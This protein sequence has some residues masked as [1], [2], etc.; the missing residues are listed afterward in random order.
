MAA[1]RQTRR[2]TRA[3][4][5]RSL[6]RPE[7]SSSQQAPDFEAQELIQQ[8]QRAIEQQDI[9]NEKLKTLESDYLKERDALDL[10]M[11]DPSI[12][13]ERFNKLRQEISR[14]KAN[15]EGFKYG[16]EEAKKYAT[17]E[18]NTDSLVTFAFRSGDSARERSLSDLK[19]M[20]VSVT[21][22]KAQELPGIVTRDEFRDK[23]KLREPKKDLFG[24]PVR[25]RINKPTPTSVGEAPSK[26]QTFREDP[27]RFLGPFSER[28][29]E[30]VRFST[31]PS[32]QRRQSFFSNVQELERQAGEIGA[33]L[34]GKVGSFIPAGKTSELIQVRERRFPE[35]G[36]SM[37]V[38][39]DVNVKL[40]DSGLVT[41]QERRISTPEE[42]GRAVGGFL[43]RAA[44]ATTLFPAPEFVGLETGR[45]RFATPTPSTE[46]I[47]EEIRKQNNLSKAEFENYKRTGEGQE[48]L[49]EVKDYQALLERQRLQGLGMSILSGAGLA[50]G[51]LGTGSLLKSADDIVDVKVLGSKQTGSAVDQFTFLKQLEG[52][53]GK[54][55]IV[56]AQDRLQEGII[57][58]TTA[59]G[60]VIDYTYKVTEGSIGGGILGFEGGRGIKGFVLD[61]SGNIVSK[62]E[63]L[64]LEIGS[65]DV[66][67]I[68]T[69][70]IIDRPTGNLFGFG[71]KREQIKVVTAEEVRTPFKSEAFPLFPERTQVLAVKTP[72]QATIDI[73]KGPQ[74]IKFFED[75]GEAVTRKGVKL[76]EGTDVEDI[77]F[78]SSESFEPQVFAE[79]FGGKGDRTFATTFRTETRRPFNILDITDDTRRITSI[80]EEA[81]VSIINSGDDSLLFTKK[82]NIK[83]ATN[84]VLSKRID[85]VNKI[86]KLNDKKRELSNKLS[87]TSKDQSA[88]SKLD[89][90]INSLQNKLNRP[91]MSATIASVAKQTISVTKTS[92][93]KAAFGIFSGGAIAKIARSPQSVKQPS[94]SLTGLSQP[95]A[96]SESQVE[97]LSESQRQ[98]PRLQEG[99]NQRA[100]QG[101]VQLPREGQRN[102][103]IERTSLAQ[104]QSQSQRLRRGLDM[105][106]SRPAEANLPRSPG[107][108]IALPSTD[109]STVRKNLKKMK[110]DAKAYDVYLKRGRTFRKIADDL[111]L[112]LALKTGADASL[113]TLAATFKVI[114][115]KGK[116]PKG[117]DVRVVTDLS[118]FRNY[119]IKGGKKIPLPAN[120]FIEFKNKRI[121]SSGEI[122]E[123]LKF[124]SKARKARGGRRSKNSRL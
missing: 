2:V 91:S 25:E 50:L 60:E 5:I 73:T 66:N 103:Q 36:T 107:V 61:K 92:K 75:L 81:G 112:G 105:S 13:Q 123:I 63:G 15:F 86:N 35:S 20:K 33:E 11:R 76:A 27:T 18:Y 79:I 21:T 68:I 42:T 96:L 111:P 93:L 43:G 12:P 31:L 77:L 34:G 24:M 78:G 119:Q 90:K 85:I 32:E 14:L 109:V 69:T 65:A 117:K 54:P 37:F 115:D 94:A 120:E 44:F 121:T 122:S 74:Q 28:A 118:S 39:P 23:E 40:E 53:G 100:G 48:L 49:K 1:E 84:K 83:G 95:L 16:I 62:I 80:S 30:F 46:N 51:T 104:R 19:P 57:R 71:G 22:T 9:L 99:Q 56:R 26:L 97:R 87:L 59:S 58:T 110:L 88:I 55:I 116:K 52:L 67:K 17:G 108:P 82:S 72:G 7:R 10:A 41:L 3:E 4:L 114:P 106:G 70:S 89:Q 38:S 29:G 6:Q 102:G 113:N 64:G 101:E 124:Q 98:F 8:Q 45:E 47:L